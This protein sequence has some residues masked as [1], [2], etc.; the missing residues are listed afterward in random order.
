VAI[1]HSGT[2]SQGSPLNLRCSGLLLWSLLLI[3]PV[4]QAQHRDRALEDSLR[5]LVEGFRGDVG[6]YVRHLP[7]GRTARLRAD[8]RFPTASLIKVPIMVALFDRIERGELSYRQKLVYRDSLYYPGEDVL[9]SFKDG[10][11]VTLSKLVLLMITMSDNTAALWCQQLAGG[12]AAINAFLASMGYHH[13][14]VNSRTPGREQAWERYGWG[15]TSPR[16]IAELLVQIYEGDLVSPAASEEMY[17]RLTASY[18]TDEALSQIPPYIQTASKQGAVEDSRSE[19]VLV[20][21]PHGPYVFSVITRNQVDTSWGYT[22]EG[23]TLIRRISRMLWHY[24]EPGI[25]YTPPSG[26]EKYRK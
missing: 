24:F 20:Q 4:L 10:E 21:A 26:M 2:R 12:G 13:T 14:R 25:P 16:E 8:E 18:W 7:S 1:Y 6:V 23:F 17:R 22:N 3:A 19:V 5:Q 15:Q 11:E 9:G